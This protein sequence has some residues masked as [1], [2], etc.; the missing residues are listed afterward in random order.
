MK[1]FRKF[2][3]FLL[4]FAMVLSCM[5]TMAFAAPGDSG[6]PAGSPGANLELQLLKQDGDTFVEMTDTEID[7]LKKDSSFF[8]GI[9]M[10]GMNT[11]EGMAIDDTNA[12]G[13][14]S[15]NTVIVY[16][17]D[18]LQLEPDCRME[19]VSDPVLDNVKTAMAT[20]LGGDA[21]SYYNTGHASLKYT[22]D[23]GF[24]TPTNAPDT[25]N[26]WGKIKSSA[27]FAGL[28]ASI[29]S[30]YKGETDC[31]FMI[32][33]FKML[34]DAEG[35]DAEN[36]VTL[37]AKG[38]D[39]GDYAL[40]CGRD[41]GELP[42][43]YYP[44]GA[45][46]AMDDLE[47]VLSFSLG[48]ANDIIKADTRTAI[49][50]DFT[51]PTELVYGTEATV[52]FAPKSGQT[53]TPQY[54]WGTLDESNNFTALD[55]KTGDK[56]TPTAAEVGK[57]VAVKVT[58][59]DAD[60][61]S[62]R[63]SKV[64]SGLVVKPITLT[65]PDAAALT[66]LEP[67]V[68]GDAAATEAKTVT[69]D[70]NFPASA[71]QT[72]D[73]V[74][75]Q[76]DITYAAS[77]DELKA[78]SLPKDV[79]KDAT[80][81]V[82][83]GK[84]VLTGTNANCYEIVVNSGNNVVS[85]VTAKILALPA[86]TGTVGIEGDVVYGGT[87]TASVSDSNQTDTSK[88]HYQW[89]L[90]GV[91]I[92]GANDATLDLTQ[93]GL[94]KTAAADIISKTITC[95]VTSDDHSANITKTTAGIGQ[96]TVTITEAQVPDSLKTVTEGK[97]STAEVTPNGVV[98][99]D[100]VKVE[101]TADPTTS[102]AGSNKDI[103]IS[104]TATLGGDDA[105]FYEITA[106]NLTVKGTVNAKPDD[107]ITNV[108]AASG[109]TTSYTYGGKLD[110]TGVTATATWQE[111]NTKTTASYQE[112]LDNGYEF[113]LA[114]D[115]TSKGTKIENG[116]VMAVTDHHDKHIV[117]VKGDT[118]I[119]CGTLAVTA[120]DVDLAVTAGNLTVKKFS[121]TN[122]PKVAV[123]TKTTNVK[124]ESGTV[125]VKVVVPG[126]TESDPATD[127]DWADAVEYLNTLAAND[128][129]TVKVTY[130]PA[131]G[132]TNAVT[133]PVEKEFTVKKKT[134]GGGGGGGGAVT[135]TKYTVKFDEGK[136][137]K[138]TEGKTSVEVEKDETLA[139]SDIPTVKAKE[140]YR[141]I[142][143]SLDGKK[144]VDPT[145]QEV[146]KAVTYTALYKESLGTH[147]IY[148][149]GDD[150]GNFRPDAPITRA[151]AAAL[152]AR[153]IEAYD[154]DATYTGKL[155]DVTAN[156]WYANEVAFDVEKGYITGYEDGT[157]RP[158]NNITRQEFCII[159]A[160]YLGMKNEG[161]SPFEDAKGVFAEGYI[162]QLVERG[163][164]DGYAEDSTF[165][166]DA[167][168][169]RAEATKI[170][171]AVFDRT[172]DKATVKENVGSYDVALKDVSTAHWAYYEILEAAVEHEISDFHN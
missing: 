10:T 117:L 70:Y 27:I 66:A 45:D 129:F 163:V 51:M 130:E 134:S 156:A 71:L 127:K 148:M 167:K 36:G 137:G 124:V 110:L 113:Q 165:R 142:G 126:A 68:S 41:D 34:K 54:Q 64:S 168:I 84:F 94:G 146:T 158:E 4:C 80:F 77:T 153:L 83:S 92:T 7:A 25:T 155:P 172:P 52:S 138:I 78:T 160:K 120:A 57:T 56:F 106:G 91:D 140:G 114:A 29:A 30:N 76:F 15:M 143:W 72:G 109:L 166:P 164:V 85:G 86:L 42:Y 58:Y 99:G 18:Y 116:T 55:G 169:S 121:A 19:G 104:W 159:V 118:V 44:E 48:K 87:L 98:S 20:R 46:G 24:G 111:D 31:Y 125:T 81:K 65:V 108:T 128:K 12:K 115:G 69:Y 26:S 32:H 141:F 2:L 135:E 43:T 105:G 6:D 16:R 107:V 157:F 73:S 50:G 119:D 79:T 14:S 123:T 90:D 151:E 60:A 147:E 154:E 49:D 97:T 162:A 136:N 93:T 28:S 53:F 5:P 63:G 170:L 171:N 102:T 67:S 38:M 22:F 61:T 23:F 88:L 47:A 149:K 39:D 35:E 8:V 59:S 103:K 101:L 122:G 40:L 161:T 150:K 152:I 89:Q 112:L 145:T 11:I 3:S 75:A 131:D 133:T 33:K 62:Y 9:K 74:K 95:V 100:T 1:R 13:L 21:N 132:N 37:F 139:K 17:S 82:E 144:I 96:K